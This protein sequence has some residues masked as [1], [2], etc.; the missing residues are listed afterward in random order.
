[1]GFEKVQT[2]AL[3][4]KSEEDKPY[5]GVYKGFKEITTQF[6]E[7]F[8]YAFHDIESM[9]M[10]NIYGFTTLNRS[11]QNVQEGQLVRI[12]YKGMK[13]LKTKRYPNGK[14][15][16]TCLVE[17]DHDYLPERQADETPK[18]DQEPF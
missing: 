6:G 3:D 4:I 12:T 7:Q 11:M 17:V 9:K 14:D 16:H 18:N 8:I 5:T 10:F 13:N 15:I 1:M 2:D